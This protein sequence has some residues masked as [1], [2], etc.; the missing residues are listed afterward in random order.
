MSSIG[1]DMRA[2]GALMVTA[3]TE[4]ER[5]YEMAVRLAPTEL[6]ALV[7][8]APWIRVRANIDT[9]EVYLAAGI[10]VMRES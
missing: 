7:P 8:L 4:G 3:P 6:K 9:G 10:N 2:L 5:L 1:C